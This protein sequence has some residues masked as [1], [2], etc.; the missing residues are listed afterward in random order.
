[1]KTKFFKTNS[2]LSDDKILSSLKAIRLELLGI[3]PITEDVPGSEEKNGVVGKLN[4]DKDVEYVKSDFVAQTFGF[5]QFSVAGCKEYGLIVL[6]VA[7]ADGEIAKE[8]MA[9]W[10]NRIKGYN[11]PD[12]LMKEFQDFVVNKKFVGAD[13]G[14]LV[15]NFMEAD[16]KPHCIGYSFNI[17]RGALYD[18]IKMSK[19]DGDYAKEEKEAAHLAAKGMNIPEAIVEQ[20]EKLVDL[21]LRLQKSQQHKSKLLNEIESFHKEIFESDTSNKVTI[22]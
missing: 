19:S 7:G 14:K 22:S 1:M 11:F 12:Q 9:Y 20:I 13:M 15:K 8:E 2:S 21:E 10:L 18:G 5:K 4:P 6:A 3:A 16:P 17:P